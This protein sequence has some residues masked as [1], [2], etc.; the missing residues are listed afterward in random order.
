MCGIICEA[1]DRDLVL[2]WKIFGLFKN[3]LEELLFFF[4]LYLRPGIIDAKN[5]YAVG[6]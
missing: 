2:L 3:D 6:D 1:S 5:M 4:F